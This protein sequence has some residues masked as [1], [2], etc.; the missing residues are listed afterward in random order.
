MMSG[1]LKSD[2]KVTSR[3]YKQSV[4]IDVILEELLN[5]IDKNLKRSID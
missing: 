5:H 2:T 1:L 4:K 3:E